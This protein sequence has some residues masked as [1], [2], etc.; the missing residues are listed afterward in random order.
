MSTC[1]SVCESMCT[2]T[3]VRKEKTNRHL[4]NGCV[5]VCVCVCL[6]LQG[7]SAQQEKYVP[8]GGTFRGLT[9]T[10]DLSLLPGPTPVSWEDG[11]TLECWG[12][13]LGIHPE[14]TLKTEDAR[15]HQ[16]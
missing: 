6:K 4:V 7:V 13:V 2:H 8:C 3:H 15:P 16:P 11:K 1:D 10:A 5:C 14:P 12:S 9:Q